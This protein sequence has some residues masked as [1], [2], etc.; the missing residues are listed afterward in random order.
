MNENP[1]ALL[2]FCFNERDGWYEMI[3]DVLFLNVVDFYMFVGE[4]L[5]R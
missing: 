3:Q 1:M 5:R 4:G 2:E